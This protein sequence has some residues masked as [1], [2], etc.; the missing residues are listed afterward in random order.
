MSNTV[1][2]TVLGLVLVHNFLN[3]FENHLRYLAKAKYSSGFAIKGLYR[4]ASYAYQQRCPAI[5]FP[6]E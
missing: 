5:V 4:K 1:K 2:N 6:K 3:L